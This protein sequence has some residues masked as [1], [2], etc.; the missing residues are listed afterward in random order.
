[1]KS[2]RKERRTFSTAFKKEK[3]GLFDKGEISVNELSKIYEVSHT[4]IY[5]WVKKYSRFPKGERVVVEK[6]SEGAKNIDLLKRIG[7]L[8]QVVGKKQLELDFYKTV[9]EIISEEEGEDIIKKY[10]PKP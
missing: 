2:Q 3:V 9:I 10:K 6:V 5:K 1:M 7:Q 4:A 8:E